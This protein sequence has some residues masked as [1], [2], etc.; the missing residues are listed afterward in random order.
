MATRREWNNVRVFTILALTIPSLFLEFPEVVLNLDNIQKVIY[1]FILLFLLE[2]F[3][4]N[5]YSCYFFKCFL[6]KFFFLRPIYRNFNNYPLLML[7]E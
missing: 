7:A 4:V 6:Q 1:Y 3:T 2:H 5:I